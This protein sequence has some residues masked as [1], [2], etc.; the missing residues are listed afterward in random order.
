VVF[1]GTGGGVPSPS[2]PLLSAYMA[3]KWGVE[4]FCQ[5]LR[6]EMR[7][8]KKPVDVCMINPGFIKPT[9]LMAAGKE[10]MKKT[11]DAMPKVA[12]EEYG[13]LVDAFLKFSEEQ[14][15]TH[16]REVG[17]AM[18]EALGAHRPALRYKVGMDS[19]AS[20]IVGLLPTIVREKLLAKSMFSESI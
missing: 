17:F 14:P 5:S 6:L 8:T 15:G 19:K 12:M 11:I 2:P 3:S 1:V 7:L 16:P 18:E 20:P 9:M 4:A 13:H 10:L